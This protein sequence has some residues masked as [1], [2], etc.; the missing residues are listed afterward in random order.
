MLTQTEIDA[1]LALELDARI[2]RLA[3]LVTEFGATTEIVGKW[4]WAKFAEKPSV[5]VRGSLKKL[6]FRW[7]KTRG[8]WQ[9]AGVLRRRSNASSDTLRAYY[10]ARSLAGTNVPERPVTRGPIREAIYAGE[11]E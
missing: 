7:N 9:Y 11:E 10:G 5:E 4:V 1:T 6:K 2:V 3:E 8:I